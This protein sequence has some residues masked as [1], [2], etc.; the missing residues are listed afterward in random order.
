[1]PSIRY[2]QLDSLRGLAAISV[3]IHH[4]LLIFP[5]FYEKTIDNSGYALVNFL[6][7]T[8]LHIFFSGTQAVILFF[9]LSGF[10]LSL[11]FLNNINS[12]YSIY[13]TRRVTRIYIP[14]LVSLVIVLI[15]VKLFSEGVLTGFSPWANGK[16]SDPID[17]KLIIDHLFLVGNFA[18]GEYNPI[19]WSLVHEMR[20]SILFPIIMIF[21]IKYKWKFSLLWSLIISAFGFVGTTLLS[22]ANIETDYMLSLYYGLS[23]VIGALLA[24]HKDMLIK[25]FESKSKTVKILITIL[26]I[27]LYT[28][29][30]WVL[31]FPVIPE[32][33]L[34]PPN[35]V[36]ASIG[37]AMFIIL[38]LAS[39]TIKKVL[40]F[41][42]FQ[43]FG[44][45]SY[46]LYLYHCIPLFVLLH[47]FNDKVTTWILLITSCI[48]SILLAVLSYYFV[49]KPSIKLGKKVSTKLKNQET[50][51][52]LAG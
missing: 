45:I 40:L 35:T 31:N 23:F 25:F 2:N 15:A 1:M 50:N 27:F 33:L 48:V 36:M 26:S 37:A 51:K 8:P 38:A 19:Y 47:Q 9:V 11:P 6:K 10:V 14:Y 7:Y 5:Q 43:F 41:K 39:K 52:K 18:N 32:R 21:I 22:H 13:L 12:S 28:F 34:N 46:S 4:Y 29:P 3:V 49:E 24:K 16:W 30:S 20:I 44:D 42:P 17:F